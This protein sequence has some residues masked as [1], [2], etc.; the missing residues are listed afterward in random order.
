[1]IEAPY[2]Y[3]GEGAGRRT[4]AL[5]RALSPRPWPLEP[6]PNNQNSASSAFLGATKASLKDRTALKRGSGAVS[7]RRISTDTA[8]EVCRSKNSTPASSFQFLE[9]CRRQATTRAESLE[10]SQRLQRS[11]IVNGG[12]VKDHGIGNGHGNDQRLG[13]PRM[14]A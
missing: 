5:A 6:R 7:E 9:K 13:L 12:E 14:A 4:C 2:G 10:S 11:T 8:V 1:M 3:G